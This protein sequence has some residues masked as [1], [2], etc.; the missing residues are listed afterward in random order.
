MGDGLPDQL[1]SFSQGKKRV[2]AVVRGY[3][4]NN[5]IK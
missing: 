5:P 2:F 1:P 4:D 3:G